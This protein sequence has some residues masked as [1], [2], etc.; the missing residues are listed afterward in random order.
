MM[1]LCQLQIPL[2]CFFSSVFLHSSGIIELLLFCVILRRF[3]HYFVRLYNILYTALKEV[4]F[5][6]QNGFIASKRSIAANLMCIT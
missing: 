5:Q 6:F 2:L 3:L 4:L 1:H